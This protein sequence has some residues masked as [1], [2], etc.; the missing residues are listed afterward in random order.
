MIWLLL[1]VLLSSLLFFAFKLFS[2]YNIDVFSAIIVNYI[3]CFILGNIYLG[4]EHILQFSVIEKEGFLP[5]ICMGTVFVGTFFLMGVSTHRS[6]AAVSSMVSKMSVVIPVL[7]AVI[8]L[9]ER[10]TII[11]LLGIAISLFSVVLIS[12]KQGNQSKFDWTLILVFIGSGMVDTGLNLLKNQHYQFWSDGK[13]STLL[14]LGAFIT[15]LS[16][17]IVKPKLFLNF[18]IKSVVGGTLLGITNFFSLIVMFA[19][20]DVFKGKT[21]LFFT[22]NNIGVVV[23]STVLGLFM[24]EKITKMGYLGLALAIL[25]LILLN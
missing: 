21:A 3:S 16:V 5:I 7:V 24:K 20:L 23:F 14:F 18:N 11:K 10:F 1:S 25:A 13:M 2:K 15:G 22:M 9:N 4:S 19:A 6:G 8:A 17:L 12:N